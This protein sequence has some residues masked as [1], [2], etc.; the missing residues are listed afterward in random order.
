MT[1]F[2]ELFLLGFSQNNYS[3]LNFFCQLKFAKHIHTFVGY[4]SLQFDLR[5]RNFSIK[6]FKWYFW[7]SMILSIINYSSLFTLCMYTHFSLIPL[8]R[9]NIFVLVT[10]F[11]IAA[12]LVSKD[13]KCWICE[14][15]ENL[16]CYQLELIKFIKHRNEFGFPKSLRWL[17]N[18]IEFKLIIS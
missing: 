4:S 2:N 17:I 14:Q 7:Y 13:T 3:V 12:L 18:L 16:V 8:I 11:I 1:R 15:V 9:S 10:Q 6:T 5:F